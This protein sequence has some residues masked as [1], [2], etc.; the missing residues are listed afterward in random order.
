MKKINRHAMGMF[1]GALSS[2]KVRV[3]AR[4]MDKKEPYFEIVEDNPTIMEEKFEIFKATCVLTTRYHWDP[5]KK[6]F[7]TNMVTTEFMR[8]LVIFSF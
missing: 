5:V 1:S 3:K 6:V 2:W 4:I 8:L 7:E